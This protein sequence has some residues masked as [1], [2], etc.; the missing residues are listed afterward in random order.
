M[1]ATDEPEMPAPERS[2]G[3]ERV[4]DPPENLQP[5]SRNTRNRTCR[6]VDGRV[7]AEAR[8]SA[9]GR[10]RRAERRGLG[11][12]GG[13]GGRRVTLHGKGAHGCDRGDREVGGRASLQ[14]S[15]FRKGHGA[16]GRMA[17]GAT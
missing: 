6:R 16:E 11:P 14:P 15:R 1:N 3:M 12:R 13:V 9:L 4:N 17:R 8:Q 10:P 2:D 7:G 5:N